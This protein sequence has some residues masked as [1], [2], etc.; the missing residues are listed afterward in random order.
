[1]SSFVEALLAAEHPVIME[2]K[3]RD[4]HGADLLAGRTV[5]AVLAAYEQAGAP[6]VSVVT[7]RWFGGTRELLRDVASRTRRPLLQKDFVTRRDQLR[8]AREL[9]ASAVLL[10]AGLLPR[11]ALHSLVPAALL[12][13]LTPFIEVT[14]EAELDGLPHAD[15]CVLA[16][17]NKDIKT[18]ERDGGDLG[19]SLRLLPAVL[20]T[21]TRCAVSASGIDRPETAA[22]LLDHGFAGLLVGTS[23]LRHGDPVTWARTVRALRRGTVPAT[24]GAPVPVGAVA[25]AP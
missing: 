16:V 20:A 5:P 8:T 4:A 22:R 13:G 15:E 9:G 24:V 25:A 17:N 21:G 1:M 7:G 2:V 11:T 19:R 6:C 23:L 12:L 18:R 10:T 14:T 3:C